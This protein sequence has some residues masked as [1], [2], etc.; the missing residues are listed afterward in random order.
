MSNFFL[1][2]Q[3]LNTDTFEN[4]K[5][6]VKD[7]MSIEKRDSHIFHRN[8]SCFN[9]DFFINS[10]FPYICN[11]REIFHIYDFFMKLSPCKDE[12]N[13]ESL[14]NNYC[15]SEQNGFLGIIFN[16][17]SISEHKKIRNNNDYNNW[18]LYYSSNQEIIEQTLGKSVLSN[19][20]LKGFNSYNKNIQEE[21][22]SKF[23]EAIERDLINYPDSKIISNVSFSDKAVVLELRIYSPVALRVYFNYLDGIYYLASIENKSNPNQN[24]DIKKAEKLLIYLK[25]K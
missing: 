22:I 15:N 18:N 5:L 19:K 16:N 13:N 23:K 17:L 3:A 4:F 24:E 11:D 6:G 25:N 21:I 8:D 14:A 10:I 20:F 9:N 7:L 2:N 12:I 1:Q